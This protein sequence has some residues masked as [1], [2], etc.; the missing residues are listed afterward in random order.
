MSH[1]TRRITYISY[2]DSTGYGIAAEGYVRCL[3]DAG[4]E[5]HWTPWPNAA[6]WAGRISAQ[7]LSNGRALV[8]ARGMSGPNNPGKALIARTS[9]PVA[10]ELCI[11]HLMP[12]FWPGFLP[13]QQPVIGMTVWET[14]RITPHWLPVL[15][16]VDHLCVPSTHNAEVLRAHADTLP[17]VSVVAHVRP[18]PAATLGAAR[19]AG[20]AAWL[21]IRPGDS[22]F[23]SIN[24]W[25]PRKR[26]AA[27]IRGFIATFS[28][29]DPVV[30]VIKTGR[31][32]QFDDPELGQD[33]RD[34]VRSVPTL[35][36]R[37]AAEAGKA[38]PR[39]ALWADDEIA[40]PVIAA[41][42]DLGHCY[43]SFSRCE[44]FGLGSFEAAARGRPVLAVG[45]GGPV[46]YLGQ[47]WPG[48]IAHHM[49][50]ATHIAGVNW[51]DA[52]QQW[53]EPEDAMACALMRGFVDDP[54]P[55]QRAARAA[56]PAIAL[57]FGA[58]AVTAA[59]E[60]MLD[61]VVPR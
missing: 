36:A 49:V 39:I 18:P 47:D 61:T 50:A 9:A 29:A 22:V 13:A 57:R 51:F 15:A 24:A 23:Y 1:A 21:D 56:M 10:A 59:L 44:G 17:P 32:A 34:L 19:L 60:A 40:E 48:R 4:H 43:V 58:E 6:L 5:V 33:G 35:I 38:A 20:L 45:Y 54:E 26:L 16:Q 3:V 46:D 41:L 28:A 55:M 30:L 11:L 52:D 7:E 42:H 53:P 27:L 25:D 31:F 14:D 2:A 37:L 8:C 12:R